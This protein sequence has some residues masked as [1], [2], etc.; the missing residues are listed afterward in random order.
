MLMTPSIREI[1][2]TPADLFAFRIEGEVGRDDMAAMG[3]RMVEVFEDRDDPVDMLLIFGSYEGAET[4]AGFS[5]P[6]IRSRTESLWNVRRYVT[7]C[8]PEGASRMVEAMG[9]VIP[10]EAHAFDT[11]AEAWAHLGVTAR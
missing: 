8:A 11:E 4:F 7:A 1:P 6:A 5:W 2:G 10:P 3:R 9:K